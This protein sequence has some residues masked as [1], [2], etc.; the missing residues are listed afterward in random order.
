MRSRSR[1][2]AR[3]VYGPPVDRDRPDLLGRRRRRRPVRRRARA[4]S[5]RRL[6]PAAVLAPEALALASLVLAAVSLVGFGLL[7]GS[8]Y[9]PRS[10]RP[11]G[12][13][14]AVEPRPRRAARAGLALLP[15]VLGV[16]ALRR[17]PES[18]PSRT[19][20]GAAVLVAAL[21]VVLR[22]VIAVRTAVD[23]SVPFVPF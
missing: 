21:S 5:G 18:S 11:G 10:Y 13:A 2:R 4:R 6:R 14:R 22:L 9:L 17:L 16:G 12:P 1:R 20:A 8:P 23:D 15:A 3:R 7:N 19:I